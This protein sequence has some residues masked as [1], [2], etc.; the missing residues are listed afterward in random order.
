[1]DQVSFDKVSVAS[2]TVVGLGQTLIL[3]GLNQRESRTGRSGVPG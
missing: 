1:V 2:Q 3:S